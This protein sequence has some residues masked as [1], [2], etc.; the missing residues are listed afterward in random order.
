MDKLLQ[1]IEDH[2]ENSRIYQ[3]QEILEKIDTSGLTGYQYALYCLL[4][5]Q[6]LIR[7]SID[8]FE[9]PLTEA[10]IYFRKHGRP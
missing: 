6:V 4:K 2:I 8:G 1:D 9:E 10:L 5:G 7:T 3:A